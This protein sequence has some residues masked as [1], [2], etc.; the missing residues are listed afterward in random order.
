MDLRTRSSSTAMPSRFSR[1]SASWMRSIR[2]R[3]VSVTA[4]RVPD[5][6]S[7]SLPGCHPEELPVSSYQLPVAKLPAASCQLPGG[8]ASFQLPVS[9]YQLPGCRLPTTVADLRSAS[10]AR[11]QHRR[12]R[13][14]RDAT[15]LDP[16]VDVI[17]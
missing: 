5:A 16:E 12:I 15:R 17:H 11:R 7:D 9:S 4:A 2:R 10:P 6:V 14:D 3:L 1:K 13:I 8:V